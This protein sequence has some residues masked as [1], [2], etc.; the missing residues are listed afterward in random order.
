MY[1]L[2]LQLGDDY[3]KHLEYIIFRTLTYHI[4]CLCINLVSIITGLDIP[5]M[6][7]S[8]GFRNLKN[9]RV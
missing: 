7:S 8:G 2:K 1:E 6:I 3:K 4:N 5:L 9:V